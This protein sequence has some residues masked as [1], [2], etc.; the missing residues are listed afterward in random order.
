LSDR[1]SL[2]SALSR[3]VSVGSLGSLRA[4]R[5]RAPRLAAHLNEIRTFH[6]FEAER[7]VNGLLTTAQTRF[8]PATE[9]GF[10][11]E[12]YGYI[13]RKPTHGAIE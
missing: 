9:L 5:N 2:F 1:P 10:E 11:D 3:D 13:D 6:G 4:D 12:N 7:V 8:N